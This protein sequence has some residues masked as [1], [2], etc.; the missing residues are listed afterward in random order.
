MKKSN[1]LKLTDE[2][3]HYI[4]IMRGISILRVML[5]HLGLSWFYPPYSQYVGIFL[6]VL[7]FVSGAVSYYSFLRARNSIEY[8]IKRLV[9][10]AIPFYV[11]SFFVF[12]L[13]AT[14]YPEKLPETSHLLSWVVVWPDF[15]TIFFPLNQVWF[16]NSLIFIVL[17]SAPLFALSK[18]RTWVLWAVF[19]ASIC[20]SLTNTFYYPAYDTITTTEILSD[21][22]WGHQFWKSIMFLGIFIYGGL[23]YRYLSNFSE[24]TYGLTALI[25]LLLAAI[26]FFVFDFSFQLKDHVKTHS[27]YYILLSFFGIYLFLALRK[28][29][30]FIL[31][32]IPK[33][34]A[35]ILYTN[36]YAYSVFLLH[37]LVLF[38]VEKTFRLEELSDEIGLALLRMLLVVVITLILAKPLGD[39][40]RIIAHR[41]RKILLTFVISEPTPG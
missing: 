9:L 29:I 25:F 12:L 37:T 36:R 14:L 8:L 34:E 38:C 17:L 1:I 16:I 19:F 41:I 21:M 26:F 13:T 35:L 22:R 11:F 24:R 7:F 32:K 31:G 18:S 3:K 28:Q 6:P 5:V 15:S 23:H 4:N 2:K 27:I 40:S 30:L 10:I 39:L 20:L 33:A